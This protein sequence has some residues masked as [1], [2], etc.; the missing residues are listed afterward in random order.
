[1]IRP[2]CKHMLVA[3]SDNSYEVLDRYSCKWHVR[4]EAWRCDRCLMYERRH[5]HEQSREGQT[6]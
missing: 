5:A 1:M 3:R 4:G 6:R 2:D